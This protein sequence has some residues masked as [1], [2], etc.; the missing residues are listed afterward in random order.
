MVLMLIGLYKL[1][2]KRGSYAYHMSDV[3]YFSIAK[4]WVLSLI[5]E[6]ILLEKILIS[7]IGFC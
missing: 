7:T 4:S 3:L 2:K 1:N 6:T 5:G